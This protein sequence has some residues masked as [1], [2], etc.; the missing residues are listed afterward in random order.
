MVK[1]PKAWLQVSE[2]TGKKIW[3]PRGLE[4]MATLQPDDTGWDPGLT[5]SR[6]P[7]LLNASRDARS[8]G[9]RRETYIS[10]CSVEPVV[11]WA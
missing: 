3:I 1:F 10:Q 11:N 6:F 8:G 4:G 9:V 7:H 5:Q 2:I